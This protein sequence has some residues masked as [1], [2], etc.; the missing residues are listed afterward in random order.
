MHKRLSFFIILLLFKKFTPTVSNSFISSG[1]TGQECAHTCCTQF[2]VKLRLCNISTSQLVGSGG[3]RRNVCPM[4]E[5]YHHR[6]NIVENKLF[7]NIAF[8]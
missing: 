6:V 8:L 1:R 3:I 4:A 7:K 5:N 2:A